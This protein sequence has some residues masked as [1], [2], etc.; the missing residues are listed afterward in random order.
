MLAQVSIFKKKE[1]EW[2]QKLEGIED[3]KYNA[4]N[5]K[6]CFHRMIRGYLAIYY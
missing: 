4:A 1:R 5:K 6:G 2:L 3:M